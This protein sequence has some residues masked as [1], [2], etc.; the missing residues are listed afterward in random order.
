MF[1]FH[2]ASDLRGGLEHLDSTVLATPWRFFETDAGWLELLGLISHEHFHVWNVKRI[3]PSVLGPFDYQSENY[4][5]SLWISEGATSYFDNL[6]CLRAGVMTRQQWLDALATDLTRYLDT[7]GRH[8]QSVAESSFDAWIRLYRPDENTSNRTVS[9]YLKGAIISLCLDLTIRARTAGGSSFDALLQQYWRQFLADGRGFDEDRVAEDIRTATGVDVGSE[10]QHWVE[11]PNDP[12][13]A[14]LL[15]SHGIRLVSKPTA[16]SALG[17]AFSSAPDGW[18]VS[19]VAAGGP[20]AGRALYPGDTIVAIDGRRATADGT[21]DWLLSRPAGTGYE[22]HLFRRD[23]LIAVCLQLGETI[24]RTISLEVVPA[25]APAVKSLL[26]AW[27]PSQG[28]NPP[29]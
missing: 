18:R 5:R 10:L 3:R 6:N 27:L 1:V 12:P 29:A 23:R 25:A 2:I 8:A 14:E 20:A 11:S 21:R 17:F 15:A 22:A 4:T 13:I 16:D 9:Y 19:S 26:D 24:A 28:E 7:P